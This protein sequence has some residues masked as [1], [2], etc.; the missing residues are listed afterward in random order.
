VVQVIV[1]LRLVP[2]GITA[3]KPLAM[4]PV[5][6]ERL[7]PTFVPIVVVVLPYV[8]FIVCVKLELARFVLTV[9]VSPILNVAFVRVGALA[10]GIVVSVV[11]EV[12]TFPEGGA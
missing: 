10:R 1:P 7:A 6:Y 9:I 2:F 12:D 8:I 5:L 4:F 3:Y 11:F